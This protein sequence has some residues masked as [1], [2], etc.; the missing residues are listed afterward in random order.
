VVDALGIGSTVRSPGYVPALDG[1]RAVAVLGVVAYHFEYPWAGGGF[2]GVD[3]FFVLSGFLITSLL[4]AEWRARGTVALAAFWARRVR[5]LLPALA[6]LLAA[7]GLY[8]AAAIPP[9]QLGR[10]RADGLW[11]LAF[12]INWH[13]IAAGRSYFDVF[14]PPSPLRHLWSLAI[15]EQFYVAWPLGVV[16]VLWLSRRLAGVGALAACGLVASAVLMARW[17]APADPSR[18]YFGTDTHAV[19]LLAG[20]LLAVVTAARPGRP[21]GGPW[22]AAAG[23]AALA[24]VLAAF[25]LGSDRAPL[26]YRGG[27]VA[28]AALTAA[29]I[30][31]LRG[32]TPVARLLATRPLVGIGRISYGVYLWHWPLFVLLTEERV[33]VGGTALDALRLAATFAVAWASFV[34]LEDPVRRAAVPARRTL[35]AGAVAAA[36]TAGIVVVSTLGAAA[37]PD[38]FRPV[39]DGASAVRRVAHGT[40]RAGAPAPTAAILGDSVAGSLLP[41]FTRVLRNRGFGVVAAVL[42]GCGI[43]TGWR[44]A[45][46]D[47]TYRDE[48]NCARAVPRAIDRLVDDHDPDLVVWLGSRREIGTR[49]VGG[50]DVPFGTRAGDRALGA[51]LERVGRALTRRGAHVALL[52]LPPGGPLASRTPDPRRDRDVVYYNTLLRDFAAEHR[53]NVSLVDLAAV[54][55]PG[56]APCPTMVE[57]RGLRPDG[58][59]YSPATA[60]WVA[61]RV[62]PELLAAAAHARAP[63]A[64]ATT[65][66]PLPAPARRWT[67]G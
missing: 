6:L 62:L 32:E 16:L 12:G 8:G 22:A 13:L 10:L 14:A 56:G 64:G 29:L 67:D 40:A 59:H 20:A 27:L 55:C 53:A 63:R 17:Y 33:G 60:T 35:A 41:G 65:A 2:L 61:K 5:R 18:V 66:G 25:A 37:P 3:V 4:L 38:Y 30:A 51:A 44:V 19:G 42:P 1:L 36:G 50:R 34:W 15:E 26:V 23:V 9:E 58:V 39:A 49:R 28:F 54:V 46:P 47:G 48:E 57:G 7:L 21:A 52:T 31:A 43:A 45:G 24:G 11:A